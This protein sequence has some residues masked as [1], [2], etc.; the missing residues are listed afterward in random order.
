M[1]YFERIARGQRVDIERS[2]PFVQ[3]LYTSVPNSDNAGATRI[4]S[5][6]W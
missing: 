1:K 4:P 6:V 3:S 5:G 2:Q